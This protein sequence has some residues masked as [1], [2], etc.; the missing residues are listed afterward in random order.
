MYPVLSMYRGMPNEGAKISREAERTT[1]RCSIKAYF[2]AGR[3]GKYA[4]IEDQSQPRGWIL[5]KAGLVR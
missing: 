1:D 5:S 4:F 3:A 2:P